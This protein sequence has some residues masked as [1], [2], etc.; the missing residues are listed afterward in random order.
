LLNGADLVVSF[1]DSSATVKLYVPERG[2]TWVTGLL[3][4][5]QADNLFIARITVI[6]VAAALFRRVRTLQM[7]RDEAT[8]ACQALIRDADSVFQVIDLGPAIVSAALRVAARHG[9]R[10]Y[11][12]LQLATVL[13]VRTLR[14]GAGL[15]AVNM[16]SADAELNAAASAEGLAVEDPNQHD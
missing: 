14:E 4:P 8:E 7:S 13:Q 16:V 1:L 5:P 9:L 3:R 10:G 6:E 15:S 2:S 12:C 11:D